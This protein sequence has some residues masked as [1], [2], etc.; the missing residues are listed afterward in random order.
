MNKKLTLTDI[1]VTIVI[2]I[3]FSVIYKIWG[4]LY[5]AVSLIGLHVEQFLYGMW[6]IAA[7]IAFLIIRKPGVAFIAEIAAAQGEFLFGGQWGISLLLYGLVQGIGC[8]LVF[9]LFRYKNYRL[10]VTCLAAILATLGSLWLDMYY[11]YITDLVWWNL[12]LLITNRTI[13]AIILSG[14]FAFY[15]VK[16]LDKTGVT[17]LV[18]PVAKEH[19]EALEESER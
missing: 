2:A 11:G 17:N 9:A 4:P 19:Y 3:V 7:T 6:F 16:A 8:E 15:L 1:L 18:R 13:G 10:Y 12:T 14:F 5:S